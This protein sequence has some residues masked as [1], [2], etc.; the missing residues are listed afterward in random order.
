MPEASQD[1]FSASPVGSTAWLLQAALLRTAGSAAIGRLGYL[2]GAAYVGTGLA[3]SVQQL[4]GFMLANDLLGFV[5]DAFHG[6][7]LTQ[8]DRMRPLIHRGPKSWGYSITSRHSAK[9]SQ[10]VLPVRARGRW[11]FRC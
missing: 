7:D 4:N 11:T 2:S 9:E 6:E 5:E 3:L 1:E 10:H 8:S